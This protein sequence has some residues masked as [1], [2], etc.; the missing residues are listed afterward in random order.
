MW[1]C[2]ALLQNPVE[3]VYVIISTNKLSVKFFVGQLIEEMMR[4]IKM[5]KAL[6]INIVMD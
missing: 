6:S 5:G 2:N 4:N 1:T 3:T